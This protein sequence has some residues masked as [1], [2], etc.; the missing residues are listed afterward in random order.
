MNGCKIGLLPL[1]LELYDR[2]MPE[3][4]PQIEA[5][6]GKIAAGLRTQGLRLVVAPVCRV[7]SECRAAVDLF[8]R[9][10]VCAV[11]TL[12]LAYS[13][14][15]E[16]A[17]ALCALDVP[18][19]ML[20]TTVSP[21]FDGATH[22]D[23]IMYNHGIHGVQDLCS[24]LRRRGRRFFIA[25]G[26]YEQSDVMKRVAGLCRAA[27]AAQNLQRARV[28]I[29]G[30]P[31]E[32]MGD[33][34]IPYA[35]LRETLGVA[36]EE[37][38]GRDA[39]RYAAEIDGKAV[40]AE[41]A[42]CLARFDA[43]DC[44]R[45]VLERS[46]RAGLIVRRWVGERG[47]T[48]FTV[49]FLAVTAGSG[50]PCMPFLEAGLAMAA[51]VGYAGE[52]DALTAALVGAL[53]QAGYVATFTE[54]FCPDWEGGTV[55][56]SHMGEMNPAAAEGRLKLIEY[57]FH[58]TDAPNPAVAC[59]RLK[60]GDAVLVNLAPMDAGRHRLVLCP[61]NVPAFT[62]P[63]GMENSVRGWVRPPMPLERFLEA[64]S[65]AGGTHH[66]ALCYGDIAGE[67]AAF[68]EMAGMD[69]TVLS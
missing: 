41:A 49:N 27:A 62:G 2:V 20:D 61:V 58:Y 26:H 11:V 60:S 40:E 25:A 38:D 9:E 66:L 29:V 16:A 50:L 56:M 67:L 44:P 37:L 48:A 31:F 43:A 15:L 45:A 24:V 65:R 4:R 57:D 46:V 13:P 68:G 1:Y 34:H 35:T 17:D 51:G 3:I 69:V 39:Q 6:L 8:R 10:D 64:Y 63:D 33:F 47:L 7:A 30:K 54:M 52:G 22:P 21:R 14:S 28:G 53:L 12:H 18:L 5:N 19:V 55:F 23:A 59:G 42:A 32:G 36:V